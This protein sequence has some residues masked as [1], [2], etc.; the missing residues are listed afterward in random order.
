MADQNEDTVFSAGEQQYGTDYK[1]HLL[2]QYK[3]YVDSAQ[4]ISERRSDANKFLLA[5]NSALVT[6]AALGGASLEESIVVILISVTG[7]LVAASWFGLITSYRNLN[8]AKFKVIHELEERLP[9]KPFDREWVIAESGEGMV[10]VPV[11]H[12]ETMIPWVF[13][14]FYTILGVLAAL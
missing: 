9:A 14:G 2:E 8:T 12:I 7:V 11:T 5:V 6:L 1:A 13:A 3:L 4:R 10:Y